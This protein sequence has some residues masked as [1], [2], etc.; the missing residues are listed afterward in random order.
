MDVFTNKSDLAA[1]GYGLVGF[2]LHRGLIDP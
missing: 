2:P 1:F